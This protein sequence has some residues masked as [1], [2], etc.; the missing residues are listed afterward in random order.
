MVKT[1]EFVGGPLDGNIASAEE[2]AADVIWT[3]AGI[4][5]RKYRK[6][7]FRNDRD[8]KTLTIFIWEDLDGSMFKE[9]SD[10]A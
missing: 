1:G 8:A 5:P 9:G 6:A 10:R 4:T 7:T 3:Q 2:L